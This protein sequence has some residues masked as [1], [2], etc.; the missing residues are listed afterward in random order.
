MSCPRGGGEATILEAELLGL[1]RVNPVRARHDLRTLAAGLPVGIEDP[2]DQLMTLG[3]RV[4][5]AFTTPPL[6]LDD[7]ERDAEEFDGRDV[8]VGRVLIERHGDQFVVAMIVAAVGQSVGWDVAVVATP[9]RA[10]VAHRVCGPPLA[11][12]VIDEGRLIDARDVAHEG[13]LWWCCPQDIA[14][15]IRIRA[16]P[17]G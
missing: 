8:D 2:L 17:V 5:A 15:L 16:A 10:L 4:G 3:D 11:M 13:D 6:A 1:G 14:R 7:A 12:S 9:Q